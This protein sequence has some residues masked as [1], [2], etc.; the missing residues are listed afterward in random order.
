MLAPGLEAKNIVDEYGRNAMHY[1]VMHDDPEIAKLLLAADFPD[2]KKPDNAGI[3]PW[4]MA[5]HFGS[6]KMVEFMQKHHLTT[7]EKTIDKLQYKLRT[8][9]ADKDYES[10]KQCLRDGADPYAPNFKLLSLL[11]EAC[12]EKNIE[13]VRFLLDNGMNPDNNAWKFKTFRY[14]P[15]WFVALR[16]SSPEILDL[17]LEKLLKYAP[18]KSLPIAVLREFS[19]ELVNKRIQNVDAMVEVLKKNFYGKVDLKDCNFRDIYTGG[20]FKIIEWERSDHETMKN[21]MVYLDLLFDLGVKVKLSTSYELRPAYLFEFVQ[22]CYRKYQ[23]KAP[24]A[25]PQ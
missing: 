15:A 21:W 25:Q 20:N 7:A 5:L 16:R 6:R 10:A 1:A 2:G 12:A 17:V 11:E 23:E 14:T 3:T 8:S 24:L 4:R 22:D 18:R 9:Y 19:L 13:F